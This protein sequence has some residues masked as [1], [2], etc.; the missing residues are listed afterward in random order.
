[1]QELSGHFHTCVFKHR[2]VELKA[3]RAHT[4]QLGAS[5][6][7]GSGVNGC[8]CGTPQTRALGS[9]LTWHTTRS[10]GIMAA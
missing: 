3:T 8:M 5:D 4:Q 6:R 10:H 7:K 2:T 1:M 9:Y